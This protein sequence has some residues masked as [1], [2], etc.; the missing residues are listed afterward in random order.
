MTNLVLNLKVL[1][2]GL[3]LM[4][5]KDLTKE[6]LERYHQLVGWKDNDQIDFK[7]FCG[8]CALCERLLAP[9]YCVQLPDRKTDPCHEVKK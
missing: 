8:I 4:M 9:E 3:N 7:T 5:G 1:P 2:K 6:Q